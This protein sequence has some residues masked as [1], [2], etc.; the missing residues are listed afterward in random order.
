MEIQT[1]AI[2]KALRLLKASGASFHVKLNDQ[3]WGEP[4]LSRRVRK[5]AK[6][7]FGS[8]SAHIKPHLNDAKVGRVCF[9]PFGDF[10]R[11]TVRSTITAYLST[12][13]GGGSYM[14]KSQEKGVEVLR[15]A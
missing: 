2:E 4:I 10:D 13:W 6:Y 12:H 15:L 7:P 8:V 14:M 9:V 3:E 1:I 11:S 5:A